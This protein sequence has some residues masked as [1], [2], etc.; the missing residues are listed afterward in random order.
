MT[1]EARAAA[2]QVKAMSIPKALSSRRPRGAVAAQEQQHQVAGDHRGHHQGGRDQRLQ[3]DPAEEAPAGEQPAQGDGGGDGEHGGHRPH[4]EGQGQ[5]APLVRGSA[6]APVSPRAAADTTLQDPD[7]TVLP[8][9][10]APP[11]D[12]PRSGRLHTPWRRPRRENSMNALRLL[13][14]LLPLTLVGCPGTSDDDDDSAGDDDDS[15]GDDDDATGDDDDATG[16]DDD[17]TG[18]DDDATGDD[19]D[20]TGDDD[21]DA[22]PVGITDIG[23]AWLGE[24]T[25]RG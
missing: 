24:P 1:A 23:G 20:A 13:V 12:S 7:D 15:S 21:D 4:L 5:R 10:Q 8:Y 3:Q 6:P 9:N 16:D 25:A 18:D 11:A 2:F 19:D 14:L 22:D 17:A